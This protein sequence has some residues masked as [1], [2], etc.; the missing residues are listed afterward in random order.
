M[1][2]E[3]VGQTC[4]SAFALGPAMPLNPLLVASFAIAVLVDLAAPIVL[5]V[6]LPRR[7]G[8]KWRYWWSGVLVFLLFQGVT[9]IPAMVFVQTRPAVV[10]T[11]QAPPGTHLRHHLHPRPQKGTRP[12]R[13]LESSRPV[14]S[15]SKSWPWLSHCCS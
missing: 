14:R 8:T 13:R 12:D 3:W 15:P 1:L 2:K 10:Q 7:L 6:F 4:C 11:L 5:A 9:R